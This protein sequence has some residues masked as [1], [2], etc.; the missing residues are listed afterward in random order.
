MNIFR[1][2][3]SRILPEAY[4]TVPTMRNST[5]EDFDE[6]DL[7][8]WRYSKED[9]PCNEF[10]AITMMPTGVWGTRDGSSLELWLGMQGYQCNDLT[11]SC[12]LSNT[13]GIPYTWT[14]LRA[15]LSTPYEEV[16]AENLLGIKSSEVSHWLISKGHAE[17]DIRG[18][19]PAMIQVDHC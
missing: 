11:L 6:T 5:S 14:A 1:S 9:L 12:E 17:S 15:V 3:M 8:T 18:I 19:S 16:A 2:I 10:L 13:R 7:D 4:I